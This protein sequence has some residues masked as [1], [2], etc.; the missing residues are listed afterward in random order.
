MADYLGDVDEMLK[1]ANQLFKRNDLSSQLVL[2]LA[3]FLLDTKKYKLGQLVEQL[4]NG[5]DKLNIHKCFLAI[6]LSKNYRP[7]RRW[8]Y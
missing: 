8:N 4:P 3:T 2:Q 7:Y 1:L 6:N 5:F